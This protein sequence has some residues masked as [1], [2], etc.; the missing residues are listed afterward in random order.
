[1]RYFIMVDN[2]VTLYL[3]VCV[4]PCCF[5]YASYILNLFKMFWNSN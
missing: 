5:W 1:M 2:K 4:C 3:E